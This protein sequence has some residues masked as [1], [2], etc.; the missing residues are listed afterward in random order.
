MKK[1]DMAIIGMACRFPGGCNTPEA[2]WE[3]LAG[4]R[5]VVTEVPADRWD[6][7][8]FK[9]PNRKAPGRSYTFAAGTLGDIRGFDAAFFGISA[10]EADMMDP[11][12]RMLL[13]MGW[14]ALE[15]GGQIPGHHAGRNCAVY[16][17]ISSTEYGSSQ[18]GNGD[19]TNAYTMLGS[20][21][22]IAANRLSYQFDLRGPSMAVDTAC[23]SSLVALNEALNALHDGRCDM[24]LVGGISLLLTPLPFVGFSKATMLSTYG[25]CRAF[26]E[27]PGGYV[28]GEGGGVVVIK[29]LADALRDGDPIHAI[30]EGSGVNTDGH[31]KGIA[32]PSHEM[33]RLLI[34]QTMAKF[35]VDPA[36]IDFFEAHGT[37]TIVGDPAESRALGEA[38]GQKRRPADG[39]L[40]I[41][42]AKTNVGHLEPASGMAGLIKTILAIRH[43]AVPK[44]LHSETLNP[45][46]DFDTLRIAPVQKL[47]PIEASGRPIRAGVN[48]FGF[49]GA[50]ATVLLRE[51]AVQPRAARDIST[52]LPPLVLSAK[53]PAALRATARNWATFLESRDKDG[54]YDAA[55]TAAFRRVRHP[56]RAIVH[57]E[58]VG[59]IVAQLAAFADEADC[60]VVSNEAAIS[61]AKVG[62][63]FNGNGAQ[64]PG[65]GRRLYAESETFRREIDAIDALIVEIAGWS[66]VEA[67]HAEDAEQRLGRTEVAQP[68]LLAMQIGLWRCLQEAG[69][70]PDA[71]AGHSVGEVAAAYVSGAL[72]LRQTVLLVVARSEAQ[73]RTRGQGRM[74]AA[75]ISPERALEI[76]RDSGGKIELAAVNTSTSVTLAGGEQALIE[77]GEKLTAEKIFF[78]LLDLDY[79]FHSR[80]LDPVQS[81]FLKKIGPVAPAATRVP[82]YS[83]VLGAETAGD[84]LDTDYW[85]NN[86]RMPVRFHD[87]IG[88][89]IS[90]GID[91]L[92]EIG[93]HNVLQPYLRQILREKGKTGTPIASM[94]RSA[95]DASML[96]LVAD[97]AF[98]AGAE[99]DFGRSFPVPGRC[100]ELPRYP[101]QHE[102]HWTPVKPD[103]DG[104]MY[105]N[106][107]GPFLGIRPQHGHALWEAQ[108]DAE[109][110][111]FL[112]D[113]NVGGSIVFPATGYVECVLEASAALF[114]GERHDIETLEI[115]RPI[116][117]V[118]G[119]ML[120]FRFIYDE[121]DKAFRIETRKRMSDDPWTLNAVG[122]LT[123][124][125]AGTDDTEVVAQTSAAS[126]NIS[127]DTHYRVATALGLNYGPAFQTIE[128][129]QVFGNEAVAELRAPDAVVA[130]LDKFVLHPAL[131]DGCLQTL[132]SILFANGVKEGNAYLPYQFNG[133]KVFR[134]HA[135][136]VRCHTQLRSRSEKSLV[137]DFSLFDADNTCVAR[138]TGLRFLRAELHN[139]S[140]GT[141]RFRFET[142]PLDYVSASCQTPDAAELAEALA[143]AERNAAISG[144][145]PDLDAIARGL[146]ARA[147]STLSKVN[148]K[149]HAISHID[150]A[151]GDGAR[152]MWQDALARHPAYLAELGA[153]MHC[154]D[155]TA[156][157]AA[158]HRPSPTSR[159]HLLESSPS[160]APARDLLM[161]ALKKV[162]SL[163]PANRRLRILEVGTANG[164]V[165]GAASISSTGAVDFTVVSDDETKLSNLE[166]DIDA[167]NVRFLHADPAGL[168]SESDL[169]KL[170]EFDIVVCP[171]PSAAS[172]LT[173]ALRGNI[174]DLLAPGGLLL[175]SEPQPAFWIDTVLAAARP[176]AQDERMDSEALVR[177]FSV[178]GFC[179]IQTATAG[180][181]TVLIADAP[182]PGDFRTAPARASF[183]A[184]GTGWLV[185]YDPS[186][187]EA[188]SAGALCAELERAGAVAIQAHAGHNPGEDDDALPLDP[189]VE[190]QWLET[191]QAMAGT[192]IDLRGVVLFGDMSA[193]ARPG[194]SALLAAR[195]MSHAE[196]KTMPRLHIVTRNASSFRATG[197]MNLT[198]APLWGIGRVIAN[199]VPKTRLRMIDLQGD[200][201]AQT[202]LIAALC[203][204]LLDADPESELV[205]SSEGSFA[206]RLRVV[207]NEGATEAELG[208]RKLTFST[209][210]LG[211]LAWQPAA[212]P[213]PKANEIVV[214]PRAAGLNFRDVMYAL[215]VL[216]EEALEAGFAGPSVGMEAAGIVTDVG[217]EVTN[218]RPG[219]EVLCFAPH[220]FDSHVVTPASAAA[221]KPTRLSFEEAATIP[222]A[223]FT[224]QY[225]LDYLARLRKGE[226][227][228]IHGAA[229]GVGL[230]AIQ[231]ARHIGA[232]IFVTVGTPEKRQMMRMLDIPESRIFD[233]RSLSFAEE[234]MKAT[235]GEGVDV[236]LNSLAGEAIHR[237][238]GLLRPFG[239]FIELGK[240]DFYENN[241]IGL[242]FFRNNLSY[243]GIDADQ[244]MVERPE[245]ARE[246]F[247]DLIERFETGVYTPLP[248]RAFDADRA[249]DAFRLMQ[250]SGHT[251]KIILRPPHVPAAVAKR[252][253]AAFPVRPDAAC[254]VTGGLSGFGLA[255]ARWLAEKGAGGLVLIGRSG[256]T[257]EEARAAIKEFEARGVHVIA[258]ACDVTDAAAV[259][260]LF[261]EAE[262][263][264]FPIRGIVH[265][266]AVFDDATMET[267]DQRQ[268]QRVIEP[269]IR[270]AIVLHDVSLGRE[271]DFFVLYS[272]I[273]TAF[274]NPGQA[275]YVAAN[276]FL[277]A[278]AQ[279][280]RAA[281]LPA[282]AIGWSAIGDA[283]YLARNAE[284]RD[285]LASKLGAD[286]LSTSDAMILLE[287]L[288]ARDE[289]NFYAAGI[290]WQRLRAGLPVLQA[291]VFGELAPRTVREGESSGEDILS[292]LSEVSLEDAIGFVSGILAEEI[293][294]V[295][296]LT[297]DKIDLG[298]SVFDLGMD[299][300]MALELKLGIEDR[301]GI[302][303]PVMAL[304]EGGNVTS[305][306]AQIVGQIRGED[307]SDQ[308]AG[309]VQSIIS[310]HINDDDVENIRKTDDT[311]DP[312]T[313]ENQFGT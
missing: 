66:L 118:R 53:S 302:E 264:G 140:A 188:N 129:V 109:L 119:H 227:V 211:S 195:A 39:P 287:G 183:D 15:S 1:T 92:V 130:T 27:N 44:S 304:S 281:G 288:V 180:R 212:M 45:D 11:Q 10:R 163:W 13:E 161:D 111:P 265:A 30:I 191:Y 91:V 128:R 76:E 25:L 65:M 133:V 84:A 52:A 228:V 68:A 113:H 299:S 204:S 221:I 215:G 189:D 203:R 57:G 241:R 224:V 291:R 88:A 55:F 59:D 8:L 285:Q 271:I 254:L 196:F 219:D 255:T 124:A 174:N 306:S 270:G 3:V 20:T 290:N 112:A 125:L 303:I 2:Y 222:T 101:W 16:V 217:A 249:S 282:Q 194:W 220:C 308:F 126:G 283:G 42:S 186:K 165:R 18:Q 7:S 117:L 50:N 21:L 280:R 85:W 100:V 250:R 99:L 278:L 190:M 210:R 105:A 38:I 272:S 94:T 6:H 12:Q 93:P 168:L 90:D 40:P 229:G 127:H 257:S 259:G 295:L 123:E 192:G 9:H 153:L 37:G 107:D 240:R 182:R 208:A 263:A 64:W 96:R 199:E 251:G 98:C 309:D 150:V 17:G 273:T 83:T 82:Y 312:S 226:R 48:S 202:E 73:G 156:Q 136:A 230:A 206:P 89:M 301:F 245:L 178:E 200:D 198:Q 269:K 103:A 184:M 311:R 75:G 149:A 236:I 144:D 104:R 179:N 152:R 114:G 164:L 131:L 166:M 139:V 313:S 62:F 67:L 234:I 209:G 248:Y 159:D 233:S 71:V 246:L 141:R 244:L 28:R 69:L 223:F 154:G 51:H 237:N 162:A 145:G 24:A 33:Q 177:F 176:V 232:E 120:N 305:L 102:S 172:G 252:E 231:V 138:V 310:R 185:V 201:P 181:A 23:S 169:T 293:G 19:G 292:K 213:I 284:M 262:A 122:R 58:T 238:L 275:N 135:L 87:A 276:A 157:D 43:R 36:G 54:Y 173:P 277:E 307:T 47:T 78:R 247:D 61:Q 146:L 95:H 60:A 225:A 81:H 121:D 110:F 253:S 289:S 294:Q 267:L 242:K 170:G 46:I 56:N 142:L 167:P 297:A 41:G 286:P 151:P 160:F 214:A 22:S 147:P 239:R 106:V 72:D 193:D 258:R 108:I 148:G 35:D 116:V 132:L 256:A 74:A 274:G 243:F 158:Q 97:T 171:L 77:L 187:A 134:P 4:G 143:F 218:I 300:L 175:L 31:T 49:G 80:V 197:Q 235:G 298:K 261:D 34:E 207:P 86:M 70:T 79:A 205:L 155:T 32:L 63:V 279:K 266:A 115:R 14:E 29:P 5:N 137:A 296:R 260:S 268:Y 216:P 26:G